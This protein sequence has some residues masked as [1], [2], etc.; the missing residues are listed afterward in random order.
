M[1]VI[2]LHTLPLTLADIKDDQSQVVVYCLACGRHRTQLV[3]F[4]RQM[5]GPISFGTINGRF[6]CSGNG[7]CRRAL[8][9]VLPPCAPTPAA[10]AS[11]YRPK[12]GDRE[13]D[14][15]MPENYF[16]FHVEQWDGLRD[17]SVDRYMG[18]L[19]D[20]DA[21]HACFDLAVERMNRWNKPYVTIRH[22][23]RVLRDSRRDF[24]LLTGGKDP[25]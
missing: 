11:A 5:V 22:Q 2:P 3:Y 21:A 15:D 14:R 6:S 8:C 16:P 19:S 20:L 24:K 10:W 13:A 25:D 9:V 18:Q 4:L 17:H 23:G 1:S 7:G 12:A